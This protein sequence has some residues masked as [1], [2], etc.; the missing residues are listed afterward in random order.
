MA[1]FNN[2]IMGGF[3]GIIGQIEGYIRKGQPVMRAR[4]K[5]VTKPSEAQKV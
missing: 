5:K 3:T 2:G 4:R 1:R